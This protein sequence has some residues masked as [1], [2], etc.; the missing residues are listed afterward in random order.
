MKL[1]L[2]AILLEQARVCL[3]VR[4]ILS[5]PL[6]VG[7]RR[8]LYKPS[9]LG[10]HAAMRFPRKPPVASAGSG[11]VF[12]A[13][14]L[15][16]AVLFA[17]P[18][19]LASA[20][21]RQSDTPTD[22]V[23]ANLA[24]GRVVIAVVKDAILIGTVENP[25][26]AGV[27]PPIPVSIATDRVGIV[28]GAVDWI[29]PSSHQQLA[30]LDLELPH[31]R[32]HLVTTAP[33][34]A[35]QGGDEASDIEA[36][37]QGLLERLDQVA[38]GLHGKLDLPEGEPLA[39]L[40]VVDYLPSYGP[41]VWQLSY[42]IEQEEQDNDYWTTRVL[43]PGY[44]QFWPPEKGQ[45]KTLVEFAYP[46]DGAPPTLVELLRNHDPRLEKVTSSDPK[47]AAAAN[48]FVQGESTKVSLADAT[49]FLRAALDAIAPPDARE[50]MA[51]ITEEEGFSWIL[52]PP[53]EPQTPGII[54]QRPADAPT[55]APPRN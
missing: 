20:R 36:I 35:V 53:R 25:I 28:L 39:E 10:D 3:W 47:M 9:A 6:P 17:A 43:R 12:I 46:P 31:L 4:P 18:S 42:G 21:A 26:E 41:E 52:A 49:Q 23:V 34:I 54:P 13:L 16:L 45:P 2:P 50:T 8:R 14:A 32:S 38:P 22:E 33:H 55:L 30:R 48:R 15:A 51:S 40:I 19:P 37:G 27:H 29:S 5:S 1:L 7:T 44:L 11:L 24:A